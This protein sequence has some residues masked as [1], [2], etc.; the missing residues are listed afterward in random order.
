MYNTEYKER[1][2]SEREAEAILSKGYLE[3]QFEKVSSMEERLGKDVSNFTFYEII[4]Y[5]K[6][7]NT[8]SINVLQVLNSQFSLY[9]QWCLQHNLVND[10]Q[11]HFLEM[12]LEDYDK[13]INKTLFNLKVVDR[14]TV[15]N[16]VEQLQNPRDQFVLLG[17]FEGIKGKDFCELANLKPEDVNGNILKLCT[18]RTIEISDRLKHIIE[19]CIEEKIYYSASGDRKKVMPLID[20]GYVIKDYPNTKTGVSEFQRGRK[21]YNSTQRIMQY[22]GVY[23]S[24]SANQIYESGKLDMIKTQAVKHGVN[25]TDYIYSENINEVK[26]KY[27]CTI[28]AKSYIMKYKNYLE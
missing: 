5:Y 2:T 26:E 21:I 18:G 25:C 4:E 1:F 15:L 11:N 17:L 24:V 16:W 20:R 28:L 27:N 12:R 6:L 10:G 7:I 9:T 14:K 23:P 19:E 13:C 22:I 3:C 8:H